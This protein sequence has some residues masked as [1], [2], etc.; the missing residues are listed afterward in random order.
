MLLKA[1]RGLVLFMSRNY[2]DFYELVEICISV[3]NQCRWCGSQTKS[4]NKS[5]NIKR[6]GDASIA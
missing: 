2:E 1:I 6:S 5:K 4:K 3:L